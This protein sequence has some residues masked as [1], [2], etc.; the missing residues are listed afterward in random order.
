MIQ[1]NRREAHVRGHRNPVRDTEHEGSQNTPVKIIKNMRVVVIKKN[2]EGN[3]EGGCLGLSEVTRT[4]F[5]SLTREWAACPQ[6]DG[7]HWFRSHT[8]LDHAG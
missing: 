7:A 4:I 1:L 3:I 2:E 5:A 8:G 6:Q